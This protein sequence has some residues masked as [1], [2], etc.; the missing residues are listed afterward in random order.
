VEPQG[1]VWHCNRRNL[2][3][4]FSEH[5]LEEAAVLPF[6]ALWPRGC[7][8]LSTINCI[9]PCLCPVPIG[10]NPLPTPI[11]VLILNYVSK[12]PINRMYTILRIVGMS[13]S[14]IGRKEKRKGKR[15]IHTHTYMWASKNA[16]LNKYF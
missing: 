13:S 6:P 16:H 3:S 2:H 9:S 12:A 8:Y 7:A 10:F 5:N 14:L 1:G 4:C 15:E 11:V